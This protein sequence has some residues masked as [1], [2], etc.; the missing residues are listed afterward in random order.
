MPGP[1]RAARGGQRGAAGL[2]RR[3]PLGQRGAQSINEE[4][5]TAKEELQASNEELAT[6]NQELQGRNLQLGRAL[7]YANGIVETVRH[8]LLILNAGLRVERA[9]QSFYDHFQLTPGETVGR[10][11]YELGEGQWDIPA[12]RQA[13]SSRALIITG[14]GGLAPGLHLPVSQLKKGFAS[15]VGHQIL[16]DEAN[17]SKQVL[18][19]WKNEQDALKTAARLLEDQQ[20]LDADL[21]QI[22]RQTRVVETP[23]AGRLSRHDFRH[24]HAI[25]HGKWRRGKGS[26]PAP[27]GEPRWPP[28]RNLRLPAPSAGRIGSCS[29]TPERG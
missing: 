13:L 25:R 9:N 10:L 18:A 29:S 2:E 23:P 16:R 17:P 3:G 11:L 19:Q 7:E 8:P 28:S 12:L 15:Q 4:L 24:A 26:S 1:D 22:L 20:R 5:E 21:E 14:G 6:L 27:R